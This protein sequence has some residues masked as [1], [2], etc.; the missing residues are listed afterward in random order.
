MTNYA[1]YETPP[2]QSCMRAMA[3]NDRARLA[4]MDALGELARKPFGNPKLQS[5][6]MKGRSGRKTFI[7]YVGGSKGWRLIW[8]LLD[9]TIVLLLFGEH[10][11]EDRAERLEYD[12]EPDEETGGLRLVAYEERAASADRSGE[13]AARYRN[14]TPG[15]LFM[16]WYDHDLEGFGFAE[17][18]IPVLRALDTELDLLAL[19]DRMRPE[20]FQRAMNLYLY[21]TPEGETSVEANVDRGAA[22]A[23]IAPRI[24]E[25]DRAIA[26]Q[27]ASPKSRESFAA[28]PADQLAEVLSKPIEDWMVFL[29]PDQLKLTQRPFSGPA[30]VRGAAGTGKTVVAMHRA[31]HLARTYPDGGVLFTTYV[32]NLPPV[33]ET[34]FKRFAPDEAPRV[35]FRNIHSW[36]FGFL[37]DLARRPKI[38]LPRSNK[39]FRDAFAKVPKGGVIASRGMPAGYYQEELEW[40][41]KGRG[42]SNREQYLALSRSGRG[43]AL[44]SDHREE[45]WAL[46]ERYQTN[47]RTAGVQ[48]FAD[49][50]LTALAMVQ[51]GR[52]D[53]R[54]AAVVIDEAQDLTEVGIRLLHRLAGGDRRDGLFMVGDGQQSVYPGGFSLASVGIDV[55]G[56]SSLLKTNYRNTR[57]IL[58]TAASLV[59]DAH[60]DDG[61]DTLEQ[62]KRSVAVIRDGAPPALSGYDAIDDHDE[63]LVLALTA[64]CEQPGVTAGDLAVLFPSNKMVSKYESVIRGLGM[65]T[66]LLTKYD[67]HHTEAVKVGTYQR[68][69]GLEFKHVFLPRLEPTSLGEVKRFNEDDDTHAERIELLKRQL[70]VAMTRA[71]DGVW[72]GWVGH[73][74]TLLG[75]LEAS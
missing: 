74:P 2:Y 68:A 65:A 16:A 10:D 55:R 48:D 52:A 26:A 60:F 69:K 53:G 25:E 70:F 51:E 6:H 30:R 59:A 37:T 61:E 31:R 9:R 34:L 20:S 39:A 33:F 71:R 47:L 23:D 29:H 3:D 75:A 7:T 50:L 63:A 32:N 56:R 44:Q 64:A 35:E 36:A 42:L 73:A 12:Y 43:T 28:V 14:D 40:V 66:Q 4:L 57:Q 13:A 24:A 1:Y 46:Y 45:V 72:A 22:E 62:G 15:T 17:H 54:Y 67:G 38:D 19:E 8:Q 27:V 18:E 58:A 49:I 41:I 21:Q 11:I 5:H